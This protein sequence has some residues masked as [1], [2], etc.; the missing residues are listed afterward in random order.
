MDRVL[1]DLDFDGP[2]HQPAQACCKGRNAHLPVAGIG[3]D[4][5]ISAEQLPVGLQERPER[6]RAC[7]LLAFEKERHAEAQSGSQNLGDCCIGCD[8]GHD[9]GFVVRG[10]AAVETPV[11]LDSGEGC[12]LPQTLVARRLDVVVR[13]EQDGRFAFRGKPA[14]DDGG[15]A[16][17]AV[18][19]VT[20]K[21]LHLLKARG[22]EELCHGFGAA[23]ERRPVKAGPGDPRNCDQFLKAGQRGVI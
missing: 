22:A 23:F 3:H 6:G 17:S 14:G 21:D 10:A 11:L 19:L 18:R 9:A 13:V 2:V 16:W 12:S 1:Q 8:V 20:A 15:A 7:F 5:D 4:D